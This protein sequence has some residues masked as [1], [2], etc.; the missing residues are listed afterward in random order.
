MICLILSFLILIFTFQCLI[1]ILQNFNIFILIINLFN[2]FL[3]LI[4]VPIMKWCLKLKISSFCFWNCCTLNNVGLFTNLL[5]IR[6]LLLCWINNLNFLISFPHPKC[7]EPLTLFQKVALNSISLVITVHDKSYC[8]IFKVQVDFN[9]LF[10]YY[11]F[12]ILLHISWVR[13]NITC[14][15]TQKEWI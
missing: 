14:G 5:L 1:F 11:F 13:N 6:I 9:F 2:Y 15:C 8:S 10:I 4:I 7:R 3:I 12:C